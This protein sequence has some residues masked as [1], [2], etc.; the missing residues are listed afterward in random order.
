MKNEIFQR[1]LSEIFRFF[2]IYAPNYIYFQK[3]CIASCDNFFC[4][5]AGSTGVCK[6]FN[7]HILLKKISFRISLT[8][9]SKFGN[10]QNYW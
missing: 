3:I 9:M 10:M 2:H 1:K 4:H 6:L 5:A 7:M 8:L